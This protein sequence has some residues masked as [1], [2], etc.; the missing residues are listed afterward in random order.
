MTPAEQMRERAAVLVESGSVRALGS[1][2]AA[3]RA[4]V[5]GEWWP[6]A[7]RENLDAYDAVTDGKITLHPSRAAARAWVLDTLR[8]EG[9]DVVEEGTVQ[10]G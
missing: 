5:L 7:T 4:M 6:S 3:I 9:W 8:A 10:D 1:I 2:A